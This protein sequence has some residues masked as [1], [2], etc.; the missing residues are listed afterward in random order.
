MREIEIER[1]RIYSG[2]LVSVRV[3]SHNFKNVDKMK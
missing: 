2:F 1:E 3:V